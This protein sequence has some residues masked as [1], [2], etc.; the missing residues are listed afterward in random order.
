M[1]S[2]ARSDSRT[3][4]SIPNK[5]RWALQEINDECSSAERAWS[6]AME[7]AEKQ[8]DVIML[9]SLA[10]IRDALATIRHRANDALEGKY[11]G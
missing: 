1:P 8:M 6:R 9:I 4:R 3:A 10:R 5:T 11:D 7:R 2:K